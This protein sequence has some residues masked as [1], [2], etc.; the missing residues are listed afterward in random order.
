MTIS[1]TVKTWLPSFC[2]ISPSG[3]RITGLIGSSG[4]LTT[5]KA[6]KRA[7][8][9]TEAMIIIR[10]VWLVCKC[11]ISPN[12]RLTEKARGGRVLWPTGIPNRCCTS[13]SY[14][15]GVV[16]ASVTLLILML[17]RRMSTQSVWRSMNPFKKL[18]MPP[19]SLWPLKPHSRMR[20]IA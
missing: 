17:L 13:I 9:T 4:L 16:L 14:F 11:I 18:F 6:V 2:S 10:P 3:V 12:L 5:I 15:F 19:L 7:A 1:I 20:L 8:N